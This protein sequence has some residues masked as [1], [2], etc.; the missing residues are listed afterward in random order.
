VRLATALRGCESRVAAAWALVDAAAAVME[1]DDCVVYLVEGRKLR[2][3]AAFGAKVAAP[4]VMES[5]ITLEL[6]VGIVGSCAQLRRPVRVD[7]VHADPRYVIDDAARGSE[8]AVPILW[9]GQVVGVLDSEHP[10]TAYFTAK[11]EQVLGHLAGI[12][13]E[14]LAALAPDAWQP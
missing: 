3:F 12:A 13:A 1:V 14:R 9:A 6:G 11:H 10:S 4:G 5:V 7:D 2:Q 8:L